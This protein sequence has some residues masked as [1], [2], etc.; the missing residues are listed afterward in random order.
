MMPDLVLH[1]FQQHSFASLCLWLT[2]LLSTSVSHW[3][4]TDRD[5]EEN[6]NKPLDVLIFSK[7]N[8]KTF[9]L[10]LC[11]FI[12]VKTKT[13][14]L[15]GKWGLQRFIFFVPQR[16]CPAGLGSLN[17]TNRLQVHFPSKIC[18]TDL[19]KSFYFRLL[20]EECVIVQMD[21]LFMYKV[22]AEYRF[23]PVAYRRRHDIW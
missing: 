22:S 3:K 23:A 19:H 21:E 2:C 4:S 9:C 18:A 12:K 16:I 13:S 5:E 20:G 7:Y 10:Y 1:V 17:N 8:V 11:L 6:Q 14:W 15:F